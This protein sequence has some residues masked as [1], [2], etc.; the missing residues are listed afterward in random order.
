MDWRFYMCADC[1]A[2]VLNQLANKVFELLTAEE[3]E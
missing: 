1:M 3:S 2:L